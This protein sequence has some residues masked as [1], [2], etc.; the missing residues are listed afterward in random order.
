MRCKKDSSYTAWS[1]VHKENTRL[2]TPTIR[3]NNTRVNK[4]LLLTH[5][6]DDSDSNG[7]NNC[8]TLRTKV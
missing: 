2:T 6:A 3:F 1:S 7:E 5:A 4:R 8:M